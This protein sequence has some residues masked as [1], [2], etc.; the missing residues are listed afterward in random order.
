MLAIPEDVANPDTKVER[1]IFFKP[2]PDV[3]IAKKTSS[4]A[5]LLI[6]DKSPT[7]VELKLEP[8]AISKLPAVLEPIIILPSNLTSPA[9]TNNA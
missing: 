7:A 2:P 4:E 1:V 5:T 9:S 8:S 3:S 6:S